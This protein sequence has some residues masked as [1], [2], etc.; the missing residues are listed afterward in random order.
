MRRS[1]RAA[2]LKEPPNDSSTVVCTTCYLVDSATGSLPP[3]SMIFH[4][5]I[6]HLH[7][8][9]LRTPS[10]LHLVWHLG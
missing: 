1:L 6:D 5:L 10:L 8:S 2:L 3:V 9:H 4:V 7:M